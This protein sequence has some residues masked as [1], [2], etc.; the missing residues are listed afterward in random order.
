VRYVLD[1]SEASLLFVGKLDSWENKGRLSLPSR[2]VS[3][4]S[5]SLGHY[6]TFHH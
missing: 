4:F 6:R 1:D 2:R 3:W 5:Q